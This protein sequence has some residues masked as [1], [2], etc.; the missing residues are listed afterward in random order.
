MTREKL[1]D[2]INNLKN[3]SDRNDE[4]YKLGLDL[5]HYENDFHE[6][7]NLLLREVFNEEQMDWFYWFCFE[8]DYGRAGLEAWDMDGNLICQDIDGL[9]KKI[10]E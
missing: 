9:Y 1:E 3:L 4:I 8:N 2:L 5:I 7:I 6:V 10:N